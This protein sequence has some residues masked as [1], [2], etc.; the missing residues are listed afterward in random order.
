[1]AHCLYANEVHPVKNDSLFLLTGHTANRKPDRQWEIGAIKLEASSAK[2]RG[3][4]S[5]PKKSPGGRVRVKVAARHGIGRF[6]VV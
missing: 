3:K 5:S 4:W 2:L 1:M 6:F